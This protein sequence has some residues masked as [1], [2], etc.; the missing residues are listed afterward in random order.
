MA[1][2]LAYV[3]AAAVSAW[4]VAHVIPTPAVVAGFGPISKDN[5]LVITQEWIAEGVTM[6]FLGSLVAALV[7]ALGAPSSSIVR[8]VYGLTAA[9]LVTRGVLTA[10][11]GARGAVIF[12][13]ICPALLSGVAALL[14]VSLLV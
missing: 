1:S 10:L 3:A 5:R 7:T 11:T 12:F 4:G 6:L 2:I 9:A 13:K 8:G 14:V